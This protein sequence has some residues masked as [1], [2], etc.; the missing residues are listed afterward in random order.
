MVMNDDNDYFPLKILHI[1]VKN[2][3]KGRYVEI[4]RDKCNLS[5]SS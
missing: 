1:D 5:L 2:M 3:D 4:E